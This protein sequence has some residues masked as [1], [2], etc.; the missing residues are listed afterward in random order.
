[1]RIVLSGLLIGV[2][3]TLGGCFEGP[4]GDKG[5]RGE[6]GV[7]GPA[8]AQG[9]TGPAGPGGAVG[10]AGPVGATG[11]VGPG[12]PAGAAGKDGAPGKDGTAAIR[13]VRQT[14]T[15]GA[16]SQSCDKG[17]LVVSALCIGGTTPAL[18]K[19]DG[20]ALTAA[21]TGNEVSAMQVYCA[22]Q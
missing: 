8:G 19:L 22:K 9:P 5:D 21:C 6:A 2:A 16:C 11:G 20:D 3:L 18:F 13:A 12:G 7:A 14:C 10:P 15:G 4:K 17:E 1:M